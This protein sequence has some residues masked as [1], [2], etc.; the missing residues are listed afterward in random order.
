VSSSTIEHEETIHRRNFYACQTI[1]NCPGTS[2][3]A[4][5]S[6]VRRVHACTDSGGRYLKDFILNFFLDKQ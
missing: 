6:V 4:R 1:R 2:E 3:R 5:Q